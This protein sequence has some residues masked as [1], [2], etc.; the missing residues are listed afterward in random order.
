M[1]SD[2]TIADQCIAAGAGA[3]NTEHYVDHECKI[4][5]S[6][7]VAPERVKVLA[8]GTKQSLSDLAFKLR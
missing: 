8:Q 1:A 2:K 7:G 5:L 3:T 4:R 6:G